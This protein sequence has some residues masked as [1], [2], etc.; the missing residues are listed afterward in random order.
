MRRLTISHP[1]YKY[2]VIGTCAFVGEYGSFLA[3]FKMVHLPLIAAN[4]ISFAVGLFIS[5]G[6]NRHWSFKNE[7]FHKR[8]HQQM[9]LY[10]GL[11]LIN[12]L[13]TNVIISLLSRAGV[14]PAVAKII[15]MACVATWNFFIYRHAIFNATRVDP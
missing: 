4:S 11:A 12:L 5:F 10:G 1:A 13:L 15:V 6:F 9:V 7:S 2:L 14:L 3:L 8:V